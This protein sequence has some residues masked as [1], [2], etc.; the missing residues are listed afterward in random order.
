MV[1]KL[2][3]SFSIYTLTSVLCA[4][5]NVLILPI[6]TKYLSEKDYG[7]TALFS[8][9]VMILS[10]VIGLSSGGYFWLEYFK[11]KRTGSEQA[12]LFSTYFWLVLSCTIV[13]FLLCALSF[14]LFSN[15]SFFSL[16]FV[17]LIPCTSLISVIGDET[18]NYFINHK[19]PKAYLI[20]NVCITLVELLLSYYLVVHVYRSWEGRI[21]AWIISLL[22]QFIITTCLFSFK[23]KYILF[24]FSKADLVKL[25]VFGF[26]LI[27]HQLGKFVINQSDRLFIAKMI[28]IDE[29]GIYSIG[30][31]VGS[32]ML[33]P[34]T[35]FANFYT[36][37]IYER[38]VNLT[39]A[40]KL[41]IVK[42]SYIFFFVIIICFFGVILLSPVFFSIFID[43]KFNRGLDYVPWVALSYVFWGVYILLAAIV[44][45]KGKTRFL[46]VLSIFNI[47]LNC[48]FNFI[49]IK[50]FGPIGAAYA[51]ALSF[52]I[53]FIIIAAYSSLLMPLPWAFFVKKNS[54]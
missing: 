47:I 32:M 26:P 20:Y 49:F 39:Q 42:T 37:F 36:P 22:L 46:G 15:F 29:A 7:T 17:L 27:F 30:Y 24:T 3:F 8:T 5:L 45:Y 25:A 14:P 2:L 31:Q 52:F 43:P 12:T 21:F 44:F 38:L 54:D 16:F 33:L 50:A 6:L 51:T 34:I 1:K 23:E 41:E 28:S 53:V 48:L 18:K 13:I 9:Y 35:A 10:P 40:K 19:K 11:K 4:L